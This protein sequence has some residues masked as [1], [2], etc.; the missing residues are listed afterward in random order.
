MKSF[1]KIIFFSDTHLGFDLPV[2]PRIERRRRG[3]DFFSNYLHILDTAV[4]EK[5]DLI[6][7]GGDMF[8]RSKVPTLVVDKAF[9]PLVE[10]ANA[11]IPIYLVPGNHERSRFPGH[12]W[13]AHK[14]IHV[15][16]KPKTYHIKVGDT[17]IALSGFPFARKV[18]QGFQTLLYQ[19]RYQEKKADICFLCVHQTFEGAKVGPSDFTFRAGPDNIPGAEVPEGFTAVLSGHI[20]RSQCLTH[21]LDHRPHPAPVIYS[22]SIERTS[23]AERFEEKYYVIIK[24]DPS[25]SNSNPIIEFHPLRTRPMVKI[26]ISTQDKNLNGLKNLIQK[27][28]A[29]LDPDSIVRIQLTGQNAM[30]SLRSLSASGLRL[31][32]PSTMNISLANQWMRAEK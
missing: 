8:F 28:L 21:T 31:L 9:D 12:L 32:A 29:S 24:I 15:F 17:S 27:N 19:T 2:Q 6:V 13:L 20:H 3:Y 26:E 23:F 30:E 14:S 16:D 7:H 25:L 5:V 4:A 10:V 18:K 11:G 22:G 1:I